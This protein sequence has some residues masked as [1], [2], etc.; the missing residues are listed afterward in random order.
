MN[1]KKNKE[2]SPI[3]VTHWKMKFDKAIRILLLSGITAEELIGEIK[4][5]ENEKN[6]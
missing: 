6:N 1:A 4:I 5:V 2:I 3:T